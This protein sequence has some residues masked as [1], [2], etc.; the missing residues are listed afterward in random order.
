MCID[1]VLLDTRYFTAIYDT[2]EVEEVGLFIDLTNGRQRRR[3]GVDG[4]SE[5]YYKQN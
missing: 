1:Y 5:L 2:D 4:E 3:A